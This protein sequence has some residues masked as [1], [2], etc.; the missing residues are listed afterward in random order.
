MAMARSGQFGV[1]GHD[2][3]AHMILQDCEVTTSGAFELYATDGAVVSLSHY[4]SKQLN[5]EIKDR[6]TVVLDNCEVTGAGK[7]IALQVHHRGT[8]HLI[9]TKVYN[10]S[11]FGIGDQGTLKELHTARLRH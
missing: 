2:E 5:G 3:V 4:H 9:S 7:G 11:K 6:G 8:V 1:D 10:E